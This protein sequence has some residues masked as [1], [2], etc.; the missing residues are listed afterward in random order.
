MADNK[1]QPR[2]LH[3]G[4]YMGD[5]IHFVGGLG[6]NDTVATQLQT[7]RLSALSFTPT[8][9][10]FQVYGHVAM[11]SNRSETEG[12]IGVMFGS[13]A[14]K[15]GGDPL[16]WV[17][18]AKGISTSTKQPHTNKTST[19]LTGRQGH[20]IAQ[21]G[22]KHYIIGGM[23]L[24][25]NKPIKDIPVYD[26][27]T[28]EWTV[29]EPTIPVQRVGHTSIALDDK[30]ILICF[31]RDISPPPPAAPAPTATTTGVAPPSKTGAAV[32]AVPT[33]SATPAVG[34]SIATSDCLIYEVPTSTLKPAR[35][36]IIDPTISFQDGRLGHTMVRNAQ[37][38]KF[39]FL[40]GGTNRAE[41]V[42]YSDMIIFDIGDI[43]SI[44]VSAPPP[45]R[46]IDPE[47][48]AKIVPSK[49]AFH[50]ATAVGG[51]G[52]LMVIFGGADPKHT[53]PDSRPYFYDMN[54]YTWMDDEEFVKAFEKSR[55][56]ENYV[57][58]W[59]IIS[60]IVG[61]VALLGVAVFTYIWRGLRKTEEEKRRKEYESRL[62]TM[63]G[64]RFSLNNGAGGR[65]IGLGG[66]AAAA[67]AMDDKENKRRHVYPSGSMDDH[68]MSNGPFK[69]TT[70]LIQ[71]PPDA[72]SKNKN[73]QL[74]HHR[75][76]SDATSISTMSYSRDHSQSDNTLSGENGY[77]RTP[78]RTPGNGSGGQASMS[79]PATGGSG[80]SAATTLN[81]GG[82]PYYNQ[83]DLYPDD[84]LSNSGNN[85]RH[86][87][88]DDDDTSIS[89]S[90]STMSP[91]TGTLHVVNPHDDFEFA[92]PNP[93]FS[94]GA[95]SA[96]N[97]QLV[98]GANGHRS[99]VTSYNNGWENSSPGGISVSSRDDES[100]RR[101][102]NSMQWVSY[103]PLDIMNHRPDSE[104]FD[105]L[106]ARSIVANG[107]M[108]TG[109]AGAGGSGGNGG[110][111][112]TVRNAS[113][114]QSTDTPRGSVYGNYYGNGM[115][116]GNSSD[117]GGTTT[118]EDSFA[119]G[120]FGGYHSPASSSYSGGERRISAALMARQQRRS[121]LRNS[122]DSFGSNPGGTGPSTLATSPPDA[123][124]VTKPI[125]VLSS[126][127]GKPNV[128]PMPPLPTAASVEGATGEYNSVE[129][130]STR[131]KDGGGL[132]RGEHSDNRLSFGLPTIDGPSLSTSMGMTT[133][134]NINLNAAL[135]NIGPSDGQ[136]TLSSAPLPSTASAHEPRISSMLNP[137]RT[138]RTTSV[139]YGQQQNIPQ[140]PPQAH[141]SHRP[142]STNVILKMPPPPKHQQPRD[143][144]SVREID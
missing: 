112:L 82:A 122:Q 41:N 80:S 13:V 2:S 121:T 8:K 31:G 125:P 143:M 133:S 63:S 38:Q 28:D 40:F 11:V 24:T 55:K 96:A 77:R 52:N 92:P 140:Q 53:L 116:G 109:A 126:R 39:L 64:G 49:R 3:T 1:P 138:S 117:G 108:S 81:A 57:S 50:S 85:R 37:S 111:G 43:D 33:S 42:T 97:R 136:M 69:S 128:H 46:F 71:P 105:P 142:G 132:G 25:S 127:S 32:A 135:L 62:S 102:V 120:T 134:G 98:S 16:R 20:S 115:S 103:E 7:L 9:A 104:I 4:T 34:D 70:S 130:M 131:R 89:N 12:T 68:S 137:K 19:Q 114:I 123:S 26:A 27:A 5:D 118:S 59:V 44:N 29:I 72:L 93:R 23:T 35:L 73:H 74:H 56:D 139:Y 91:W 67:A 78:P 36:N 54:E 65:G 83:L 14:G 87:D 18:V 129:G 110:G 84:P 61:A 101:S 100:H 76:D 141:T 22:S 21:I 75:G 95:I 47:K 90:E 17:Q 6:A 144:S 79:T 60:S 113:W 94:R 107:A 10:D 106:S 51:H 15:G 124:Y 88:D 30:N 86:P 48:E 45:S 119:P 58:V 99:S 66:A